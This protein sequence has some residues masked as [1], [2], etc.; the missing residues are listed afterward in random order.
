MKRKKNKKYPQEI[1]CRKC[2]L[3][4]KVQCYSF[5]LP[6]PYDEWCIQCR[7]EFGI[8]RRKKNKEYPRRQ[9]K[10]INRKM[11]KLLCLRCEK[12]FESEI[13]T[14]RYG[15]EEHCHLC[16]HCRGISKEMD[17]GSIGPRAICSVP[18]LKLWR[19]P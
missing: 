14:N 15:K 4:K 12:E 19:I 7:R 11:I 17:Q 13:W 10:T 6:K 5:K 16:D 1:K 2:R 3:L 9:Q 8:S 18:N